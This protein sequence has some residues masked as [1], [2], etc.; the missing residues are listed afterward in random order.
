MADLE[1]WWQALFVDGT[2]LSAENVA[3]LVEPHVHL[4]SGTGIGYGWY[5]SETPR[6]TRSVWSR[7]GADFGHNA[8]IVDFVDEDTRVFVVT[9][10]GEID[11]EEA[12]RVIASELEELLFGEE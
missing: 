12:N 2:V 11:G 6:G 1:Q 5:V 4:G 9:C 8:V 10:A 3:L 7:G